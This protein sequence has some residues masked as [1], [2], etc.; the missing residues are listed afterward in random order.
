[1]AKG[2]ASTKQNLTI[3]AKVDGA[4]NVTSDIKTIQSSIAGTAATANQVTES[5]VAMGGAF[6]RL[7]SI[8]GSVNAA[9]QVA[10]TGLTTATAGVRAMSG[11]IGGLLGMFG[12]WITALNLVISA[13]HALYDLLKSDITPAQKEQQTVVQ[14]LANAYLQLGDEATWAAAQ[15][16]IAADA[17]QKASIEKFNTLTAEIKAQ[18]T[19]VAL[20]RSAVDIAKTDLADAKVREGVY[21]SEA[22][23]QAEILRNA[24]KRLQ[25]AEAHLKS[26]RELLPEYQKEIEEIRQI[27]S[28]EKK[29]E[30]AKRKAEQEAADRQKQDEADAR[31][32]ENQRKQAAQRAAQTAAAEMQ[33]IAN[34]RKQLD[35]AQFAA[36]EHNEEE[37]FERQIEMRKRQAESQIKDAY[38]LAEALDII[39]QTADAERE[40]RKNDARKKELAEQDKW[41]QEAAQRASA[42]TAERSDDAESQRLMDQLQKVRDQIDALE[43]DRQRFLMMSEDALDQ[44][45]DQYLQN[46]NAIS[47]ASRQ[48]AELQEQL[49]A[50]QNKLR[51]EAR[52]KEVKNQFAISEAN[53]KAIDAQVKG[54][55]QLADGLAEAGV[56]ANVQRAAQMTAAGLQAAAD[57]IDYGAEAA[58]NFAIGNVG[59]GLGLAAAAAGKT[60]AAVKYAKSLVEL[61]FS[62]FDT[63]GGESATTQASVPSTSQMTG[64]DAGDKTTEIN[65]TMAFTG[66]AGRLGRYLVEEINAEARTPGGARVNAGVIR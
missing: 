53:R 5:T 12:P 3:M 14:D 47:A 57:A 38:R 40:K 23:K 50:R 7:S 63:G 13:G 48:Q 62:A 59:T 44:Y 29:R 51:E 26:Q 64:S 37:I 8:G 27:R 41:L 1:M 46:E 34:L 19:T 61:G 35:D 52:Y 56:G 32:R 21:S 4:G 66:Q 18:E 17:A 31:D 24:E 33:T 15:Q 11:A 58:A 65:V 55:Q 54:Y 22:K 9:M 45:T 42:V 6:S 20:A 10:A 43:T 39:D 36:E 16:K 25:Q 60:A 28:E 2:S 49:I 30:E